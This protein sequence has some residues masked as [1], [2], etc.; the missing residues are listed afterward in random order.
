MEGDGDI[1]WVARGAQEARRERDTNV[2][3][4]KVLAS[5]ERLR[6]FTGMESNKRTAVG[7]CRHGRRCRE[8]L[9]HAVDSGVCWDRRAADTGATGAVYCVSAYAGKVG[10]RGLS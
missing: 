9:W 5:E 4:L 3:Q 10:D 8:S 6:K 2:A 7:S 1:T